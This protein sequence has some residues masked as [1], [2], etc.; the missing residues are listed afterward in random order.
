MKTLVLFF[1]LAFTLVSQGAEYAVVVSVDGLGSRY[2]LN[3][4]DEGRLPNFDRLLKVSAATLNARADYDVTVT[5]P[6]HTT[7]LTR[8]S[9]KGEE[10]HNWTHNTD[11]AKGVTLHSNKGR[12]IASVFDVAHDHGL[13]TGLWSTK[14]KFS[15]FATSYD[16]TNGAPDAGHPDHGR[17]KLDIFFYNKASPLLVDNFCQTMTNQPCRFAFVHMGEG[18]A[19][20]H[21]HGWGSSEYNQ[22]IMM[23]DQ[24]IGRL[25]DLISSSPALKGNTTLIVT[26]DH[27]GEGKDHG[28]PTKAVD[29]TI[30]FI[31]WESGNAATNLYALNLKTR[32][33]PGVSRPGYDLPLQPI[34]NGEAGNLALRILGLPPI[35]G[36][37]I[38]VKQ[39]LQV[40]AACCADA[41]K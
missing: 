3:L 4:L 8:R 11:P 40:G 30:P 39:D 20:G 12:Y 19:A 1:I 41:R 23:I 2:L 16:A 10:G 32:Q 18:D 6:N 21:S 7:M 24:Q 28:D 31:V 36:S 17:N 27:G 25:L 33:D 37:T 13:K 5:L 35:P 14:T 29:Y 9:V 15:L 26:A 38:N 22:A 34:R